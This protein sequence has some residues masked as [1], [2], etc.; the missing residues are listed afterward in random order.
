MKRAIVIDDDKSLR[1]VISAI[2]KKRGYE[3]HAYAGPI[4]CPI[5]LDHECP[6]PAE[7]ACANIIITDV[8]MPNVRGPEFI[9]NQKRNGCKVENI[10]VMSGKWEDSELEHIKRFGCKIFDKPFKIDELNRWL[11]ECEEKTEPDFK[12]SDLPRKA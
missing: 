10:A 7:H 6:C 8:E 1:A 11:D 4:H 2:L 3:V 9:E 5:Y 12:L